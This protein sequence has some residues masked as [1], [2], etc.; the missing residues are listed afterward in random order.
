MRFTWESNIVW[1][2]SVMAEAALSQAAKWALQSFCALRTASRKVASSAS[3]FSLRELAKISNPFFADGVANCLR[4]RCIAK[5]K[6]S[7]WGYAIGLVVKTLRKN[8]R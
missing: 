1:G 4:E 5:A 2:S 6:P 7:P 8:P 3:A